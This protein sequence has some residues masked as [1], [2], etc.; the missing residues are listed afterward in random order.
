MLLA[1]SR[2]A[3]H[4]PDCGASGPIAADTI[5]ALASWSKSG[6]RER[7]LRCIIDESPDFMMLKDWDGK[8]LVAN[9]AIADL[10]GTTPEQ[11]VGKSDGDFNPDH[12][13]VAWYRE[14]E[15]EVMRSGVTEMVTELVSH[16]RTGAQAYVHSV[17]QPLTGPEGE[18]RI[19]IVAR[20]VTN[21]QTSSELASMRE[22]PYAHAMAT[23]GD[24]IWDW[25]MQTGVVTHNVRWCAL[26]GQ[27]LSMLQH[28]SAVYF[29]LVLP[30]DLAEI[31]GKVAAALAGNGEFRHEHQIRRPSGNEIWVLNR[32]SV[33]DRDEDGRPTRMA[34]TT[35]DITEFKRSEDRL[36]E[37][38][39]ILTT[40]HEQ[41]E[42]L[43]AVR[44]EEL[45]RANEELQVLARIDTLTGLP[46]RMAG[47]EQLDFEF[48]RMQRTGDG[49]SVLMMDLDWFKHI[50]DDHGHASGDRM[51]RHV[52]GIFRETVR[53]SDFVARFGGEEFMA[54]LP[55]T[56]STGALL[57]AEK[58][59]AAVESSPVPDMGL[60]TVSIGVATVD[61]THSDKD[62]AVQQADSA[63]YLAKANGRNQVVIESQ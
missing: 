24:G 21:L 36:I 47:E 5:V 3:V 15:Q 18:P 4:C 41:L 2:C 9:R 54:L 14:S 62:L 45:A 59:R 56:G 57:I 58:V 30:E 60:V 31:K 6:D 22:N 33:V 43:V 35:T 10:Y 32:G 25:D 26:M 40:S 55:A 53:D 42:A 23:S 38:Q 52:A 51:L 49:Y 29:D 8:Y 63:M 17:K 11:L 34:G 16:P 20:N 46:N 7:L 48:N 28:P 37:A 19:V 44:T 13:R 50:N 61:I 12:E 27:Q 39:V 1:D